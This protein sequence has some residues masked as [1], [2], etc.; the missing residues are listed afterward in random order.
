[1]KTFSS[2]LLLL[3][4]VPYR[5]SSCMRAVMRGFTRWLPLASPRLCCACACAA[6]AA[7]LLAF[8]ARKQEANMKGCSKR[9]S[10][11]KASKGG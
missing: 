9:F 2:Q 11:K 5:L 1:M 4:S 3:T 6:A 10:K 8:Q 7:I